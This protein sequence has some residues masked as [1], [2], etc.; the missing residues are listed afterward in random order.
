MIRV[1]NLRK[2]F[3]DQAVLKGIT[4]TFEQGRCNMVLG[5]SGSGKTVLMKCMVGLYAP[6]GGHVWY[7][8]HDFYALSTAEKRHI[9]RRIGMLFQGAA[10]FDSMTLEENVMLPLRLYS[11][12]TPDEMKARVNYCLERVGL[13]DAN[14]KYPAQLSGGM[15]KRAG[16]ARAIVLNPDY[17]FCDEPNSGLDPQTAIRID[18]L[19]REITEEFQT[20]TVINTHDMNSVF[21]IGDRAYFLHKGQLAW[22]GPVDAIMDA[23]EPTLKAFIFAGKLM[24]TLAERRSL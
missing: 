15:K 22:Q 3:N 4:A 8:D 13:A 1:E 5:A 23:D 2:S 24:R 20:V 17:L 11:D 6:D 14:D 16:L 10:L 18:M 19:I 21:E 12:M 9:R 7:D